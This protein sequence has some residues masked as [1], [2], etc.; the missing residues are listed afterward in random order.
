[1]N[2]NEFEQA[3]IAYNNMQFKECNIKKILDNFQEIIVKNKDEIEKICKIEKINSN[4]FE[5]DIYNNEKIKKEIEQR[6]R[7]DNFI[8]S[9]F[10]DSIG[11]V[12]IIFDGNVYVTIELLKKMILTK[13]AIVFCLSDKKYAITNLIVLYFRQ[14]LKLCGCDENLVQAINSQ[15]Y[16][17]MYKHNNILKKII[18][19][20]NKDLQNQV[21]SKSKIEVIT[22]G[23]NCFDLYIE[24]I[25]DIELIK[26]IINIS[27]IELYIYI[28][29]K[30]SKE[31]I[32]K[33]GIDDYTEVQS[34]EECIRDININSSGY[35]SS[36]FTKNNDNAN[37]FLKLIK[38]KNVFVNASPTAERT[39]DIKGSDLLYI[40]QIMYK[41]G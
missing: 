2:L 12:G 19:I 33:L 26:R 38:S 34:V 30:I 10:K 17:E 35:S 7:E 8:V 15:N 11:V 20:G 25:I 40:K 28:N 27:D 37:K 1:M 24:D 16:E 22:S 41:N 29:S 13:N 4:L 14:A 36:I 3:Q 31:N 32:E 39:L 21:L 18:V 6:K 5:K 23:Y 9:K